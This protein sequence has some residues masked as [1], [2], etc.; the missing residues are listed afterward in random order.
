MKQ[1]ARGRRTQLPASLQRLAGDSSAH[2]GKRR[3]KSI[4]QSYELPEL[5]T[6]VTKKNTPSGIATG[7]AVGNEATDQ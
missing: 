4:T 6:G 7:P 3:D 5:L 2:V 1:K